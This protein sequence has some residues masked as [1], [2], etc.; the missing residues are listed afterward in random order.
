[1]LFVS[2]PWDAV[3]YWAVDLETGGLDPR[4]A[5]LLAVGM[6]PIRE[7]TVRL[8]EAYQSLVRPRPEDLIS[9]DSMRA[10]QLIPGDVREAPL[11]QEVLR[12]VDRRLEHGVLLVHQASIDVSF[13]RRAHQTTGLRWPRPRIVDTVDLV[14]R[15]ARR[16]HFIDPSPPPVEPL[17]NLAAARQHY[18][19]P[20]YAAHDALTDAVATAELFLVL[21]HA[22]GAR[23]MRELG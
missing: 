18:G 1:L 14:M 2:P 4:S 13:L 20:D 5:A 15:A 21:R 19:L 23:R 8:A 7:G 6:V 11:L 9:A 17:L 22:L 16:L 10:H 3:T 12:E